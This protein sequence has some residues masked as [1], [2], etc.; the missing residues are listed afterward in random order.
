MSKEPTNIQ[1]DLNCN[2]YSQTF[3]CIDCLSSYKRSDAIISG[4]QYSKCIS[5]NNLNYDSNCQLYTYTSDYRCIL[6]GGQ[7][8]IA[9]PQIFTISG[10][11][12]IY[13]CVMSS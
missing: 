7:G 9:T 12:N 11:N 10:G 2:K 8:I 5:L 6:C 4:T 1:Y 3:D 13:K